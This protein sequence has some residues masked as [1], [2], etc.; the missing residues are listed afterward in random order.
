MA[1]SR[2]FSFS[3]TGDSSGLKRSTDAVAS[4]MDG[5]SGKVKSRGAAIATAVGAAFAVDKVVDFGRELYSIGSQAEQWNKKADIVFG[6]QTASVQAWADQVAGSMGMTQSELV[7]SAAAMGDLLVPMGASR[8]QAASMSMEMG[9]LAGA[10]SAWS[11]G[12]KSA[13]E[14]Q[15]L[16]T[17]ALLGETDGLKALGIGIDAA[18]VQERALAMAKA[19]GRDEVSKMDEALATQALILEKSTDAQTAW[20]DGTMDAQ[21]KQAELSAKVKEAKE[22]LATALLPVFQRVIAFIVDTAIPA[23][24]RFM[25]RL[26]PI[27]EW[28]GENKPVLA[29]LGALV[30]TVVVGA[31]VAWA[32][33]TLAAT[34]PILAIA[35]GVAALTAAV[36][37]AYENWGWFRSAVDAVASFVTGTLIPAIAEGARISWEMA[38]TVIDVAVQIGETFTSIVSTVTGMPARIRSAASGMWDGIKDAF[39]SAINWIINKWNDLSFSLPSI[40]TPFGKVGGFSLD[41]PN[42]D[43]LHSGGVVPGASGTNVAAILQAGETVRS[44]AQSRRDGAGGMTVNVY[45]YGATGREMVAEI[46]RAVRDGVRSTWLTTAGVT[47]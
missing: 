32:A 9:G 44:A 26:R 21:Q 33:A 8:E 41:T 34:W 42:I 7:G 11:G 18:E 37:Y 47:A 39:R 30:G 25:T 46:E 15:E 17:G 12:S 31:F 38:Q 13:A 35:V 1:S 10:L 45:A 16:L 3:F 14:V 27:G 22:S 19:D 4:E 28:I 20:S 36:I 29:A 24:E 23:F 40:D 5:L 2:T 6:D 43:R